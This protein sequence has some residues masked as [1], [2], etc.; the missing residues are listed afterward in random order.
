MSSPNII[1]LLPLEKSSFLPRFRETVKGGMTMGHLIAGEDWL[2]N[3]M[4]RVWVPGSV[5]SV[6][7][8]NLRYDLFNS[9]D[10]IV[11]GHNQV[12]P[13]LHRV[14]DRHLSASPAALVVADT[15]YRVSRPQ[16]PKGKQL[17]W[18]STN[19]PRGGT[20]RNICV[21][22]QDD[23][24]SA[25]VYDEIL[26]DAHQY[27]TVA[28]LTKLTGGTSIEPGQHLDPQSATL[29]GLLQNVE[30]VV[31]GVFDE[32]SFMLWSRSE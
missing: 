24:A 15:Y 10:E 27:T 18:F 11:F 7:P 22:V 3:G 30:H 13:E 17:S 21:Y 8:E 5:S 28:V 25:A 1:K 31:I 2:E 6:L 9:R 4:L 16:R 14:F 20:E 12:L 19:D 26:R 32:M 23:R 29:Q